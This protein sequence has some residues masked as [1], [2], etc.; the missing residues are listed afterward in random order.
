MLKKTPQVAR[1]V[2]AGLGP[3]A[4]RRVEAAPHKTNGAIWILVPKKGREREE[5]L[6]RGGA[7]VGG[8][9]EPPETGEG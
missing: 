3:K 5:P 8:K 4:S 6:R 2:G 9:E 7:G 1:R